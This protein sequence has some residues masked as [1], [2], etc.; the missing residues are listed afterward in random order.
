MRLI[1]KDKTMVATKGYKEQNA[2]DL[3]KNL[4]PETGRKYKAETT[5]ETNK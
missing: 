5:G 4:R 2:G 3:D 1:L